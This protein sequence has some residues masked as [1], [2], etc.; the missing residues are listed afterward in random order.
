LKQNFYHRVLLGAGIQQ[1]DTVLVVCGGTNDKLSL[2]AIG[3]TNAVISN[4][5]F[6]DG[7][8]DYAPFTWQK[9]DAENLTVADL[10]YD[11]CIVHAG[12]HHC[13]SPHRALCEMLR[14]AKKGVVVVESRDSLLMRI[15]VKLGLTG[16]YELDASALANGLSGGYRNGNIPNFIYRWTEREIEKTARSFLPT[17]Q[18]CIK[19]FYEYLIPLEGMTMSKSATKRIVAKIASRLVGLFELLLPKQGNR[20]GFAILKNGELMPWLNDANGQILTNMDYLRQLY[21]PGNYV[22]GTTK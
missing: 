20:F 11:W 12:L 13:G 16:R 22:R 9:Q 3:V 5:D 1:N 14:V 15:A 10:S 17:R 19:Y 21:N 6:H 4:V 2:Q 18:P 7:I 8:A